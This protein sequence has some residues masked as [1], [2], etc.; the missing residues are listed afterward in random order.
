MAA[1][2]VLMKGLLIVITAI[3]AEGAAYA[4]LVWAGIGGP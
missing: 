2:T 1:R 3:S 4:S